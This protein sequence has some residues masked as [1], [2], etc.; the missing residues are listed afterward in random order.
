MLQS[1]GANLFRQ[2]V[3]M[4]PRNRAERPTAATKLRRLIVA[5]P[6]L[7]GALL[8]VNLFVRPVHFAALLRLV[9]PACRFES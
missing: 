2:I 7:T 6:R 9:F 3:R 8:L 4:A 5:M 1:Q